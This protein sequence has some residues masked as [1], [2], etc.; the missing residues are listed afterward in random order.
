VSADD[1]DIARRKEDHIRI[2]LEARSQFDTRSGLERYRFVHSALPELALS[3]VDLSTEFLGR[4]WAAPIMIS[5]MTG[6]L[7]EGSRIN[8]HLAEA[9]EA[10]GL[11]M[12]VGSQRV[13]LMRPETRSSFEVRAFAPKIPL[14]ANWGAVQLNT[15]FGEVEAK[16]AVEM[17]G[18]DGLFLHLNAAQE[19]VQE[20][21]DTDF[22]GLTD[23]I[24]ALVRAVRFPV[25]AKE[26]GA[27]ISGPV[28]RALADRGIAAIDVS[29]AGGTSWSRVEGLRAG[30][31]LAR[32]LSATFANWGIP[33]AEAI[34]EARAA[35]PKTPLIASGGIRSGLDAAKAIALGADLVA[36]GQPLLAA[37][38][39]STSAVIGV[40]EL[41]IAELRVACF[42]VGAGNVRALSSRRALR[43]V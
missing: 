26:C 42:L 3:E 43:E 1:A 12:G 38:L 21:G 17:I 23:R 22:R 33:T 27:G 25:L 9:A 20:G 18:A 7:A 11:G 31:E 34:V 19:A 36:L 39:D 29:G 10:L 6:G 13:A 28:A 32:A 24:G 16:A 30:S 14:F 2:C 41:I 8:R 37:A 4:R 5:S 15:G 35:A 40:L